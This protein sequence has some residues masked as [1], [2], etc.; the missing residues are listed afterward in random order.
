MKHDAAHKPKITA[1]K[2]TDFIVSSYVYVIMLTLVA[3]MFITLVEGAQFI[4]ASITNLP[5]FLS[6]DPEAILTEQVH[7]GLLHT[8]AF[9]IV[10]VKAYKIL[11]SYAETQH[12]NLKFLVEI[13]IIAPTVELLFNTTTYSLGINILFAAFGFAN[14]AAYLFFYDTLKMVSH[15]YELRQ[16][17]S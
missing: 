9:A 13:A 10:L 4:F 3:Y 14:L 5:V 6:D 7:F 1:T 8:I 12:I 16:S 17:E 15:D 2:I 11:Q